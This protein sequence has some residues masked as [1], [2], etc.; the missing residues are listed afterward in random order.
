MY[1]MDQVYL[2]ELGVSSGLATM[3]ASVA[4]WLVPKGFAVRC[5]RFRCLSSMVAPLEDGAGCVAGSFV[6][7]ASGG[8]GSAS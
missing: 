4:L 6:L 5:Y 3:D 2:S 7:S 1:L 8:A